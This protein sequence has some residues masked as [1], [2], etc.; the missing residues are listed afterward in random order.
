MCQPVVVVPQPR[1]GVAPVSLMVADAVDELAPQNAVEKPYL[2]G[3]CPR[4]IDPHTVARGGADAPSGTRGYGEDVYV[5][6]V[7]VVSILWGTP[8]SFTEYTVSVAEMRRRW[9]EGGGRG[10]RRRFRANGWH[11]RVP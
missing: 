11:W 2:A 9:L 7:Q 8:F 10:L 3:G 5:V 6:P 1:S 4:Q